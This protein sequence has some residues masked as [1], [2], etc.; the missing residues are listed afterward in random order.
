MK[1]FICN[2]KGQNFRQ[3]LTSVLNSK[4]F[5][6]VTAAVVTVF[7]YLGW[8]MVT[9]YYMCA[10]TV[11]MLLLLDDLTPLVAQF[12]F[13]HV[14][15]SK[16]HSPS[17]TAMAADPGFFMRPANLA[18]IIIILS[19][20][21]IAIA[22]RLIVLGKARTFKPTSV[23]WGLCALAAAFL[24]NG[25]FTPD[26]SVYDFFYG[27]IMAALFL[28]IF[29]LVS[30]NVKLC[31]ENYQKIAFSF[32]ALSLVVMLELAVVYLT[33]LGDMLT[34]E[35]HIIKQMMVFGWGIWN[36]IGL[37]LV[38]SVPAVMFLATQYRHGEWF[39]LYATLLAVATFL[40]TSRQSMIGV[41]LIYP[42]SLLVT[43]LHSGNRKN[44]LIMSGILFVLAVIILA[45]FWNG[46]MR[47][48]GSV[49]DDMFDENGLLYGN[50]R[51][52]LTRFAMQFFSENPIFGS[53]FNASY[54]E[55]DFTG[56][57]FVPEFACNT[58]AEIFAACGMVGFIAYIIHRYQTFITF[59]EDP[60][61]NKTYTVLIIAA[62]LLISLFDNHMFNIFPNL[63]YS[64]LLV[65]A[66]G[67][68]T[69]GMSILNGV[70]LFKNKGESD[71][72]TNQKTAP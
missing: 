19:V 50:G 36:T 72:Y 30:A 35:G 60:S 38:I 44:N 29:V 16:Q 4:Y 45:V 21:F 26:Y 6:F 42:A 62:I 13:F 27:L 64:G 9:F 32:F 71:V 24:L 57:N 53:G 47:L 14:M 10:V 48:M 22:A 63:I 46:I 5:P 11:L 68:N 25:A 56:L 33:N 34:S 3:T 1:A 66:V 49:F 12:P 7:Y 28:V 67:G 54:N 70:K 23:F 31:H 69:E 52:R 40:T 58:F 61:F 8:D 2:L 37:L 43:L 65:F 20:I 55:N 59:I 15:I 17:E 39:I 51:L 41:M 18:Q